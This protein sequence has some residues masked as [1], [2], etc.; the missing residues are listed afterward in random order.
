MLRQATT[1]ATLLLFVACE[2]FA[3]D[4]VGEWLN[5]MNYSHRRLNYEGVMAYQYADQIRSY[6]IRHFVHDGIEYDSVKSLDGPVRELVRQGHEVDCVH[7]G[8]KLI[9][10]ADKAAARGYLR[11]YDI[12]VSGSGRVAGREV[13]NLEIRPRDVFR[14][15]YRLSLDKESGLLL[16]SDVVDQQGRVLERFQYMILEFNP[17]L[18]GEALHAHR[19]ISVTSHPKHAANHSP[20]EKTQAWRPGWLPAGFVMTRAEQQALEGQSYTDGLSV[21]SV[22]V[23]SLMAD[24]SEK[25]VAAEGSLQRGAS[26]SYTAAFPSRQAMVTVIGE[27]PL[28]TARQVAKSLVWQ[29]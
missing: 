6:K 20:E 27:V 7:M 13:V 14:L 4:A 26:V 24:T 25:M 8:P 5:K 11:Y 22:F 3:Q 29:K 1:F 15:G 21:F 23:E 17:D 19:Q 10:L 2:S 12:N 9:Q 18:D 16:R 28:L